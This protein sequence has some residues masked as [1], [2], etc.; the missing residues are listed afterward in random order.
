[1]EVEEIFKKMNFKEQLAF[2][3]ALVYVADENDSASEV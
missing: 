3:E 2:A 1:V